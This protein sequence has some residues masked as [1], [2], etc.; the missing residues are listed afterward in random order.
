MPNFKI[1]S[2]EPSDLNLS[3]EKIIRAKNA[4][5]AKRFAIWLDC[6]YLNGK[7]LPVKVYPT[8]EDESYDATEYTM[9]KTNN[10]I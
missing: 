4:T 2:P 6:L 7:P 5:Q 8:C 9:D 1:I 3:F 10:P